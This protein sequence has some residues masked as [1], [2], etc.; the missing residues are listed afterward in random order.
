MRRYLIVASQT[1]LGDPPLGRVA[2]GLERFRT[3]FT[4]VAERVAA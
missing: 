3:L 1:L 4:V 2:Q